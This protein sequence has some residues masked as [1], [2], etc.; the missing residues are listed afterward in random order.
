MQKT[1]QG[2]IG[3]AVK[4]DPQAEYKGEERRR[5]SYSS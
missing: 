3:G 2:E 1:K 4:V 5:H